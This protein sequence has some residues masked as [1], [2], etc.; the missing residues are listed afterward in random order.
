ME[1]SAEDALRINV[2]LANSPQ[3]IRIDESKMIL[4]ALSEK[5]EM[6]IQLNP[7]CRDEQYLKQVRELLSSHALGTPA[8]YPVHIQRWAR[9]GQTKNE[10]L[11]ELLLLGEPEAVVA[12]IYAATLSEELARRAWWAMESSEN[13]RQLLRF[14]NLVGTGL[15]KQLADYLIEFLPFETEAE[16]IMDSVQLVLQPGLI[17]EGAR[18]DV[19]KKA[20]RKL[21]FNVGFL[22]AGP[23]SIPE[24]GVEHPLLSQYRESLVVAAE[25]GNQ[26]ASIL[27][28]TLSSAGQAWLGLAR[29]ILEKPANQEVVNRTLDIV[30]DY[31]A[32]IR[33]E[34]KVDA[35]LEELEAE[36]E[37]WVAGQP[38]EL[39]D[40]FPQ[41]VALRVL[42]GLGYGLV[43]PVL[44]RTD[45]IGDRPHHARLIRPA[46]SECA[47]SLQ[48]D[49]GARRQRT[50]LHH[51]HALAKRVG[52]RRRHFGGQS[53]LPAPP[54][55]GQRHQPTTADGRPQLGQL[56]LSPDEAAQRRGQGG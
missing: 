9:M 46:H 22:A 15:G 30:S 2:M 37:Q 11:E 50:Q 10:N 36:A 54:G 23:E 49:P 40:L 47:S 35:T 52:A 19:W 27:L 45:A 56:P 38:G 4:Y 26:N 33:P 24:T 5:G 32:T 7:N 43:R 48:I 31:Y 1:L 20:R 18:A 21:V 13:A 16:A 41:L 6:Q 12:V 29:K 3:A 25:A 51:V 34:G 8:G 28:E 39:M 17:N 55:P 42:S 44:S 53:R 14:P